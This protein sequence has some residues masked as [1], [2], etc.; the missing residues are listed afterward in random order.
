M[1]LVCLKPNHSD[2]LEIEST[3]FGR[4]G[5]EGL[6]TRT[7]ELKVELLLGAERLRLSRRCICVTSSGSQYG[8]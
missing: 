7:Q 6:F 3:A 5:S 8:Y 2:R 4:R 1:R